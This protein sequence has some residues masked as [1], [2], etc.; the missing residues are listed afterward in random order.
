[1]HAMFHLTSP[2]NCSASAAA[3]WIPSVIEAIGV[4]IWCVG[5]WSSDRNVSEAELLCVEMTVYYWY[6]LQ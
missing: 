1:M 2:I 6:L 4:A 3:L 5:W